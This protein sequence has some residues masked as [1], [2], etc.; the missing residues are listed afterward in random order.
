[1]KNSNL[2][3]I[4]QI[5]DTKFE[6]QNGEKL[7]LSRVSS[8]FLYQS[9][10]YALNDP[11]RIDDY[12]NRKKKIQRDE[13]LFPTKYQNDDDLAKVITTDVTVY[14]LNPSSRGINQNYSD[15]ANFHDNEG[16]T[17]DRAFLFERY[18]NDCLNGCYMSDLFKGFS[19][20]SSKITVKQFM[21]GLEQS[22]TS[23]YK[24]KEYL[25]VLNFEIN[26][27]KPK[28]IVLFG[29][30]VQDCFERLCEQ[31]KI[32]FP[33]EDI[34]IINR[35]HPSGTSCTFKERADSNEICKK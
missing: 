23:K 20:D 34:C 8:W 32:E 4:R 24:T 27:I 28:K 3:I 25:Q 31:N 17:R 5:R 10:G 29:K 13:L 26:L 1:M 33:N 21:D 22:K 18:N 30:K 9:E 12:F 11:K 15:W 2:E 6:D 16:M 14:G 35:A 19:E 7:S